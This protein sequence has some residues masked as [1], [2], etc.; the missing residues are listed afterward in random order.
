MFLVTIGVLNY[1]ENVKD[2]IYSQIDALRQEGLDI[3]CEHYYIEKSVFIKCG[4]KGNLLTRI[5]DKKVY[6][7]FKFGISRIISDVILN[8][9]EV[10]LLRKILK[11][12]YFYLTEKEREEINRT[13]QR[14]LQEEKGVLPGGFYKISRK[15]KVMRDILDYLSIHENINIDGFVNFRLHS[16]MKELSETL[17]R[18]IEMFITE[19][20]YNEFIKLLKYFVDIQECKLDVLHIMPVSEE[21]YMLLDGYKNKI[22][23]EFFDEIRADFTDGDI[24]YDDLLISTLITISPRKIYMHSLNCFPNKELVRTITNVFGDRMHICAG[25]ELCSRNASIESNNYSL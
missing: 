17:E 6:E 2:Y 24:N 25:C 19:R 1:A 8:F 14:L 9:W 23:G 3:S 16:Y 22:N 5:I 4:L 13:A 10:K 11:D 12:N 18:A 21:K 7:D 15:N 20:E